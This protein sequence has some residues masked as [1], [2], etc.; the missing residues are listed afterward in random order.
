LL[1][2]PKLLTAVAKLDFVLG[3]SLDIPFVKFIRVSSVSHDIGKGFTSGSYADARTDV[4]GVNIDDW[5]AGKSP[6]KYEVDDTASDDEKAWAQR[7]TARAAKAQPNR[8][9]TALGGLFLNHN[10]FAK[11][12]LPDHGDI[13]ITKQVDNATPQFAYSASAQEP[14]W[15][16]FLFFRRRIGAALPGTGVR[17]PFFVIG[18][19]KSLITSWSLDGKMVEKITM[20]YADIA[21]ASNPEWA[22]TNIPTAGIPAT[23]HWSTEGRKGGSKGSWGILLAGLTAGLGAAGGGM[24][25]AFDKDEGDL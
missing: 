18:L 10:R 19:Y 20:N 24:S 23:R 25:K 9:G 11:V 3:D 4:F 5:K 8:W 16:T 7:A 14:I 2:V 6:E 22:D 17:M 12:A 21:W 15:W 1:F 13:T